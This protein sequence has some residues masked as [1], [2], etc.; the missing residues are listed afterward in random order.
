[1]IFSNTKNKALSEKIKLELSALTDQEL[2]AEAKKMRSFSITNDAFI[3]FLIGILI[4]SFTKGSWGFLS[5]IPLY[6]IYKLV[7]HPKNIC[8]TVL[9]K[10]LKDR[11]SKQ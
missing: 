1:M 7:S 2:S 8:L 9:R 6:L 10:M 4:Y 5:L 11:N 3:G